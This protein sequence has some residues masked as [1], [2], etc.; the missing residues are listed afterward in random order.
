MPQRTIPKDEQDRMLF[1]G[2]SSTFFYFLMEKAGVEKV[3]EL[4]RTARDGTES[5]DYIERPDV[6]GDDFAKIEEEWAAWVKT[7]KP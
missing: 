6:L 2:Q 3:R 7:L 4:I 1:D 5:R